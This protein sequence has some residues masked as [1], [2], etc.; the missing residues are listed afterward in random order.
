MEELTLQLTLLCNEARQIDMHRIIYKRNDWAKFLYMYTTI[1][2]EQ[3]YRLFILQYNLKFWP[4]VG[5]N[6]DRMVI[7]NNS[8]VNN[9]VKKLPVNTI[10]N[11]KI[12]CLPATLTI[13]VLKN[14]QAMNGLAFKTSVSN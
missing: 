12:V 10:Y 14:I 5:V 7:P 9:R 13:V 11:N 2:P 1:F 8:I 4:Q 3:V 6:Q